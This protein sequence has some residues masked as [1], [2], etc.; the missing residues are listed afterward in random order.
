MASRSDSKDQ[1]ALW[2]WIREQRDVAVAGAMI[3]FL[4]IMVLPLPPFVLD[5]LL[6]FSIATSLLIFLITLY[7][8]NPVQ[9]SI[10]PLLLL[11]T[12]LFRLSLLSLIH[13]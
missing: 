12:T 9:F 2:R 8:K 10:F 5:L 7:V 13:I 6:A 3:A 4:V 11:A 1:P